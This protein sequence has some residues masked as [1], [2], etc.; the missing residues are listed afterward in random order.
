MSPRCGQF[1]HETCAQSG[2]PENEALF[3]HVTM[4]GI[5]AA[6]ITFWDES[7]KFVLWSFC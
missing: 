7:S 2:T 3:V 1:G 6:A 5:A 4:L